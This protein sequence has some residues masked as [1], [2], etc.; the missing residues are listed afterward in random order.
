MSTILQNWLDDPQLSHVQAV[1]LRLPDSPRQTQV[2]GS[3]LSHEDFDRAL[4]QIAPLVSLLTAQRLLPGQVSWNFARGRLHY[5]VGADQAVLGLYCKR[6]PETNSA[7]VA[8][9]IAEF[10]QERSLA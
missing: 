8:E 6:D 10:I 7:A 9:L 2:V 4:D 5:V 3:E 1:S